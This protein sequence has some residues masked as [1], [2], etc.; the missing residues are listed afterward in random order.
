[1]LFR[2]SPSEVDLPDNAMEMPGEDAPLRLRLNA[3]KYRRNGYGDQDQLATEQDWRDLIARYW[4]M[5][6]LVDTAVGRI[7]D[8]LDRT[9]LADNTIVVFTSDHGDMMSSHN[10]MGKGVMYE[11]SARV[12]LLIRTP[13]QTAQQRVTFPVSHVDMVPTLLDLMGQERPDHLEGDTLRPAMEG[14]GES[15]RRDVFVEWHNDR[16]P[17]QVNVPD[18]AEDLG[19]RQKVAESMTAEVRTVVSPDG[20]KLNVSTAGEHELYDLNNDSC[21]RTNLVSDP[22]QGDRVA[23]MFGR[24]RKW[25]QRTGDRLVLPDPTA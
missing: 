6:S 19:P 10:L 23:D 18:W 12:P 8:T 11:E 9:G 24:I 3:E 22:A 17:G 5:C 13:G 1:V 7:L 2:S 20:W 25:Q 4:G 16:V 14:D 21:E 15:C